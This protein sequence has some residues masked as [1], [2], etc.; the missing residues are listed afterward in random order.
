MNTIKKSDRRV[1]YTKMVLRESLLELMNSKAINTITVTELCKKADINRNT[2]YSH[3][4]SPNEL[5][6]SIESA[7]SQEFI[8][9]VEHSLDTNEYNDLMYRLCLYLNKNQ[10]LCKVLI[11]DKENGGGFLKSIYDNFR[12]RIITKW[13]QVSSMDSYKIESLY[14]F[15]SGGSMALIKEWVNSDFQKSPQEISCMIEKPLLLLNKKM[16][17]N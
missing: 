7:F 11:S 16:I 15:I 2:F 4:Q 9:K 12:K 14:T 13:A 10:D 6:N 5:L 1:K 3:Y 8:N 17:R